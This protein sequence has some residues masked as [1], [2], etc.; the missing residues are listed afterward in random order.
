MIFANLGQMIESTDLVISLIG[1]TAAALTTS[2]FLPQ[3]IKAY[4]T[5][6]MGDVSLHLMSM[7]ASGT[8]LWIIYGL[9]KSDFVIVG[10]I[11]ATTAL[12]IILLYMKISYKTNRATIV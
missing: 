1:I 2:S 6:S 12:N 9:F 5:K 3:I 8:V 10:A 4:R 11:S 7:F